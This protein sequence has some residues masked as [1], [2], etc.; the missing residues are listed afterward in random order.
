MIAHLDGRLISCQNI[1]RL[2]DQRS[3]IGDY[4][5]QLLHQF[6]IRQQT[7]VIP[8][9][10]KFE[11]I[12][13]MPDRRTVELHTSLTHDPDL[14]GKVTPMIVFHAGRTLD[15]CCT[16]RTFSRSF[17]NVDTDQHAVML[18]G[19]LENRPRMPLVHE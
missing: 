17:E 5:L 14:G 7:H 19:C 18:E 13:D 12:V 2:D 15:L 6:G 9:P 3:A 10:R 8:L 4:I 1:S 11:G 16:P